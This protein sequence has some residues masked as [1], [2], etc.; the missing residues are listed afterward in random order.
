MDDKAR[1]AGDASPAGSQAALL[2]DAGDATPP[3][4]CASPRNSSQAA[5]L[6]DESP[7]LRGA[8]D[9]SPASHTALLEDVALDD[10]TPAA[11]HDA[12]GRGDLAERARATAD[13]LTA[14]LGG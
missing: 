10:E 6:E 4:R 12:T 11:D 9:A 14:R 7:A 1:S 3:P 8:G 2:E 13:Q 5:L